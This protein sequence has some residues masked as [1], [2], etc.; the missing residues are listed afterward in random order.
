MKEIKDLLKEFSQR[1]IEHHKYTL[2]DDYIR[3]NSETR[4]INIVY[5]SIKEQENLEE[6]L[7]LIYSDLPEVACL[8]A[9]YCMKFNPEKCLAVLDKLSKEDTSII[10]FSAEYAIKNWK[11][12]EW[13]ID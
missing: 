4:K 11:N 10:G 1:A 13:Y 5:N 8:A 6:L 9:T 12:G 7:Q 2:E 3:V